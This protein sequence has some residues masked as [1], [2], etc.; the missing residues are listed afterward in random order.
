[1]IDEMWFL[2]IEIFYSFWPSFSMTR[3]SDRKKQVVAFETKTNIVW[4]YH[5]ISKSFFLSIMDDAEF[6]TFFFCRRHIGVKNN[7]FFL[8]TY[9][10]IWR[11]DLGISFLARIVV[12]SFLFLAVSNK[13]KRKIIRSGQKLLCF[14]PTDVT[15]KVG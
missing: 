6:P 13:R 10:V 15:S 11:W 3:I 9:F 2:L 5:R 7:L 12:A 1:M 14:T 4:N 8:T